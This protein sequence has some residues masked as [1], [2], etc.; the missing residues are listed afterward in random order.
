MEAAAEIPAPSHPL[1][2]LREAGSWL[3]GPRVGELLLTFEVRGHPRTQGSKIPGVTKDGRPFLREA[4]DKELRLWR[5]EVRLTCQM[6]MEEAGVTQIVG[7]VILGLIFTF[8]RPQYHFRQV[9]GQ[10]SGE[11]KLWASR[12]YYKPDGHDTDKL[13]RAASDAFK[14][15]GLYRDDSQICDYAIGPRKV[16]GEREGLRVW[17]WRP[18]GEEE[19]TAEFAAIAG[20]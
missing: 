7:G 2:D 4:N 9:R 5:Q 19:P 11:L 16:Y 20:A 14:T 3:Q 10:P 15:A 6:A 8:K 1:K 12:V 17:V 13:A 18:A